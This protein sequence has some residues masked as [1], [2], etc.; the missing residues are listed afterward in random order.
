VFLPELR[1]SSLARGT[2]S[3]VHADPTGSIRPSVDD[4][5]DEAPTRGRRSF[6]RRWAA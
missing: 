2:E 5:L 3:D 1:R 4:W 6:C